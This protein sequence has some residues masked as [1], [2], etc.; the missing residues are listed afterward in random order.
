M[1]LTPSISAIIVSLIIS[2]S[3]LFGLGVFSTNSEYA[4][5]YFDGGYQKIGVIK[6]QRAFSKATI[7][8]QGNTTYSGSFSKVISAIKRDAKQYNW[9]SFKEGVNVEA[10]TGVNWVGS[11][12]NFELTV[13]N[14]TI[15]STAEKQIQI[16]DLIKKLEEEEIKIKTNHQLHA[17]QV[18]KFGP[19]PKSGLGVGD[20][21]G[22]LVSN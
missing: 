14:F 11:Q 21:L 18:L 7:T 1:N 13:E 4:T 8:F 15:M 10:S 9:T 17:T 5:V 2:T 22:K 6:E 16:D 20:L 19:P 12:S 3:A